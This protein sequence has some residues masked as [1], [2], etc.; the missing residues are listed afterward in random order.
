MEKFLFNTSFDMEKSPAVKAEEAP[1]A[2]AVEPPPAP[3]FS[4]EELEAARQAAF[5]EGKA[6]GLA[7][8]EANQA[9]RLAEA[10]AELPPLFD[11]LAQDL[12]AQADG[13]R[14]ET[15]EAAIT[16]VRKLFPHLA[17]EHG[18][19][20]TRAVIE[21]CLERLRDEPRLVIRSADEDLDALKEHIEASAAHSAFDGKLVFLA[22]DRLAPGDLRLEWA[23][24]GAE[25]DQAGLWKEIDTVI[26]RALAPAP[27]GK[28]RGGKEQDATVS[29]GNKQTRE[30]VAPKNAAAHSE[31]AEPVS[32]SKPAE[33]VS[34]SKPAEPA[35]VEPLRR[36]RIA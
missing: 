28:G 27:N 9:N 17:R 24:G 32:Q 19:D 25:R 13:Q 5:A 34:Q 36:A 10:V 15:L 26:D 35:R 12:A 30:Q 14:R 7:E 23:D 3:T 21:Q 2:A 6:D 31:P 29:D 18:L 16:V 22:D 11:R 4:E 20:E 33:P 8:A 1:K